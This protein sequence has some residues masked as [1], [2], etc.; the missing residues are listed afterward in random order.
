M[1][2]S[3]QIHILINLLSFQIAIN[4]LRPLGLGAYRFCYASKCF[5]SV[6]FSNSLTAAAAFSSD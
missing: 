5:T 1:Q 4:Y 3:M 6:S 2:L